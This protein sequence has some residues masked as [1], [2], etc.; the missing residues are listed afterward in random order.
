M[1]PTFTL[2]AFD[3][4]LGGLSALAPLLKKSQGAQIS[5]LGDLAN[6][7]YGPKSARRISQLTLANIRHLLDE[8]RFP[9]PDLLI[10]A[11]NT[12]SAYALET[13]KP[14]LD[15]KKIPFLGVIEPSCREALRMKPERILVL[16]TRATVASRAY[17]TEL[18]RL[19]FSGEIRSVACPLFVPFVEE[20]VTDG[21][22]LQWV[23]QS[24]LAREARPGDLAILGCT[25]YPFLLEALQKEFSHLKFVHAGEALLHEPLVEKLLKASAK[26][27]RGHSVELVFTDDPDSPGKLDRFLTQLHLKDGNA[28]SV[29]EVA[30]I[31]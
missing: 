12:A 18:R 5:Y 24:Y 26:S 20:G 10:V 13:L 19:G 30:P 16:A 23:V 1:T 17:E 4:G 8:S 28:I 6:L 25:H 31:I 11:C 29:R 7:P 27:T 14:L 2:A 9:R 15:E 3:S 21:P 22:A